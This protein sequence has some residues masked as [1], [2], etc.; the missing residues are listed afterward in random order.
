LDRFV[1]TGGLGF[2]GGNFIHQLF[3]TRDNVSVT[4]LDYQG[5]GSNQ[6]NLKDLRLNEHYRFVKADIASSRTRSLLK[7]ADF[8]VHFAAETHVDRSIA[9]P[10][11]FIN[12]NLIG[13]FNIL[14]ACRKN[15]VSKLVHI[16]TDEVYGS[17]SSESF[18]EE[19]SLSPT[20]PYSSTKAGGDL[21][22]QAWNSTY[23]LP[24]VILRCTNNFGPYQH[25][26][27]L[28]PKIIIRSIMGQS[29]PL[30]GGGGQVRDWIYVRDFCTAIE[31]ALEKGEPGEAYNISA[32]NEYS[33]REVAERL[34]K[35]LGKSPDTI[36]TVEDR[37]G[38]DTRY[39]LSSE[40][41]S[42]HLDWKPKHEF[43]TAL[44]LTTK[45]YL[46]NAGWWKPLATRK[47]LSPT[48]WKEHW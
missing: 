3:E 32:G 22:A 16:S 6:S 5:P 26:E 4:N 28:I 35:Q 17:I 31:A 21:M 12:S 38:H 18:S 33:N 44:A 37:P 10:G 1:V 23:D 45:W 41:A 36:I 2:I 14:E 47:A 34:V 25:P 29:I 48:P 43:D 40:K 13:T 20:S 19:D 30:Y 9:N 11:P 46:A 42:K 7:N 27:K 24:V 39:S 15:D 8:V